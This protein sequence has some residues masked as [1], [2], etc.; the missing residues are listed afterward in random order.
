MAI[1]AIWKRHMS[2]LTLGV[3]AITL[4]AAL[5]LGPMNG[6]AIIA[7]PSASI[8]PVAIEASGQV[9]TFTIDA[10]TLSGY[11]NAWAAAQGDIQTPLG[12]T[13]LRQM[14]AEIRDNELIVSGTADVGWFSM[15]VE[16]A[17]SASVQNGVVRV[18][19]DWAHIHGV[20]VP[21]AFRTQI[22]QQLQAQ[23]SQSL[24]YHLSVHSLELAN[25]KLV[26]TGTQF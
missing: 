11:L 10:P 6:P 20:N 2:P 7:G 22:E 25:G 13:R 18:H 8:T 15:P 3:V 1:E 16:A 24:A 12:T 4:F 21:D 9:W 17:A 23:L 14:A 5:S 26:I 19:V